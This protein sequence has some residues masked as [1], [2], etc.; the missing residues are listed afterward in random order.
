MNDK[1]DEPI[2]GKTEN[3]ESK[4]D[5]VRKPGKIL[6]GQLEESNHLDD[7]SG[8]YH[9]M[10]G[11]IFKRWMCDKNICQQF[12]RSVC[13]GEANIWE[14]KTEQEIFTPSREIKTIRL[15]VLTRDENYNIYNIEAQARHYKQRH[16]DR[17]LFYFSALFS[18][19]LRAGDGFDKLKKTTVIFINLNNEGSNRL[20]DE[21][22]VRHGLGFV[23]T[24]SDK[25]RI[26]EINLNNIMTDKGSV[27][28]EYLLLFI[29]FCL[30]GDR[31]RGFELMCEKLGIESEGIQ[32]LSKELM[33]RMRA[34]KGEIGA[35]FLNDKELC[36]DEPIIIEEVLPMFAG[37]LYLEQGREQGRKEGRAQGRKEGEAQ[38]KTA[39]AQINRLYIKEKKLAEEIAGELKIT[40]EEVRTALIELGYELE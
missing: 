27:S 3:Q 1:I 20:L 26:I 29:I 38:G 14:V 12:I 34:I 9:P 31:E 23:K 35:E 5:F 7:I 4:S 24:Y 10:R 21:A 16:N 17:C 18:S 19:Q 39:M 28:D 32:Q 11:E 37:E 13:G 36:E 30:I 2:G 15:D 22:E 40:P 8:T 33:N 6:S 25:F